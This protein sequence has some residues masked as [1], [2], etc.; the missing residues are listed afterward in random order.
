MN[1]KI[2][3]TLIIIITLASSLL[4]VKGYTYLPEFG[5]SEDTLYKVESL[6][7]QIDEDRVEISKLQDGLKEVDIEN[8]EL[9]EDL[10][11]WIDKAVKLQEQIKEL[12][13]PNEPNIVIL[14]PEP[15][16]QQTI[17]NTI[18]S[19]VHVM[20]ETQGWQGS[21]VAI[22]DDI[23]LTARHVNEKGDNFLITTNDG[24]TVSAHRAISHNKYDLGFIQIDQKVD[25]N[26]KP[27]L[28]PAELASSKSLELAQ[29]LYVIGSPFGQI[30]FNSVTLGIVSGI[31]R[32]YG[33]LNVND[34]G[35]YDDYGWS[36]A[37]TTDAAGHP[38]NSGCPIFTYDGKVRGILVGG[39][40]P[41]L[42][43]AMPVD[44]I[45][46][47]IEEIKSMFTSMKYHVEEVPKHGVE[48]AIYLIDRVEDNLNWKLESLL[49]LIEAL[50]DG[51][52]NNDAKTNELYEWF[53]G[54]KETN[55]RLYNFVNSLLST[56]MSAE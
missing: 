53:V 8:A 39:F 2:K 43:I 4:G 14:A 35:E 34:Y 52:Q 13:E 51:I 25:P 31:N 24:R 18:N 15:T 12:K 22:S 46:E 27:Y 21:G 7:K 16:L 49:E 38:G 30:N 37:F 17:Q 56:S 5:D 40:S 26:G 29:P 50:Q 1:S 20:N 42:I 28:Q 9:K 19:V 3:T 44:L 33:E 36:I 41:V 54:L 47:D 11:V 10:G 55:E 32:D 48:D 23:I 45:L 6:E